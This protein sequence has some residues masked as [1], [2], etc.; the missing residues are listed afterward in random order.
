ME[1]NSHFT[2]TKFIETM[3][4]FLTEK[5]TLT[6]KRNE[7]AGKFPKAK[8]FFQNIE[9]KGA[10]AQARDVAHGIGQLVQL[11]DMFS[12]VESEI[13]DLDIIT[14]ANLE[15]FLGNYVLYLETIDGVDDIGKTRPAQKILTVPCLTN[16]EVLQITPEDIYTLKLVKAAL[17]PSSIRVVRK[18]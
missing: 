18:E 10:E 15:M 9:R 5:D 8:T 6:K 11:I 7:I 3:K 4:T 2:T 14:I 13:R 17:S 1:A 16:D 12:K